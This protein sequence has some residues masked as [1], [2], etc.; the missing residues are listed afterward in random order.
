[1]TGRQEII[2]IIDN[3]LIG[4]NDIAFTHSVFAQCF[5]PI[6][7]LRKGKDLYQVNHGNA[8]LAVRA[9]ILSNPD[10]ANELEKQEVP[11]GAKARLLFTYINDQAIRTKSPVI[12]MGA[13]MRDFMERSGVK[14]CGTN[15]K[16][17]ARQVK[18][19]AASEIILGIWGN[20]KVHHEQHKVSRSL[21]FWLE[22]DAKQGTL[23][24][25]EMTLST[26]YF[27]VLKNHRIPTDFRVLVG[28][29]ASPRAMDVYAW[30]AYRLYGLKNPTKIPY[31]AL[32]PVFGVG[33]RTLKHF[34]V[35]FRNAVKE[36]IKFYP[37]A[38]IDCTSD[39]DYI[40]LYSSK[41]ALP[42]NTGSRARR[43]H[44]LR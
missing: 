2:E 39:K 6:R 4:R 32:H 1:M 37:D 25:P 43:G 19:V 12:D 40:T 5:L 21:S 38:N 23:W 35:E 8:S 20:E 13:S 17:L 9:G 30:L 31:A 3:E 41:S 34:K 28:L 42:E 22:K 27:N 44:F 26:D 14:S 24:K 29:Q 33:I 15:S 7:S 36:V 10:N 11:A 18:N 16:E